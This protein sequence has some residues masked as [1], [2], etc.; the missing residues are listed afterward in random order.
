MA[1]SHRLFASL[2]LASK[3][4]PL[5]LVYRTRQEKI[6]PLK[7][8]SSVNRPQAVKNIKRLMLPFMGG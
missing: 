5:A 3:V 1:L 4:S 6:L 8:L 2:S 7:S